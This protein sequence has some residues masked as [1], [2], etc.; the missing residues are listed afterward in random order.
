MWNLIICILGF[1]L[2]VWGYD[3]AMNNFGKYWEFNYM[4]KRYPMMI[5]PVTGGLILVG[6]F[7]AFLEDLAAFRRNECKPRGAAEGGA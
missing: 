4:P 2:L 5:L 3:T 7:V 6:S 1:V